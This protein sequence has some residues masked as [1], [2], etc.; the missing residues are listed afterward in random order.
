MFGDADD[1]LGGRALRDLRI[2]IVALNEVVTLDFGQQPARGP[3]FGIVRVLKGQVQG[4]F[5]ILDEHLQLV[6]PLLGVRPVDIGFAIRIQVG[7]NQL[8]R[9]ICQAVPLAGQRIAQLLEQLADRLADQGVG[10]L[11]G[12][13]TLDPRRIGQQRH[14]VRDEACRPADFE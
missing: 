3:Y 9:R 12:T 13:R 7:G 8:A 10:V 1:A 2:T 4:G 5:S 14:L 6:G 11:H